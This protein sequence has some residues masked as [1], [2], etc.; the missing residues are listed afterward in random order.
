MSG[1]LN[2]TMLVTSDT[3]RASAMRPLMPYLSRNFFRHAPCMQEEGRAGGK[4][5]GDEDLRWWEPAWRCG[6]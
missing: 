2:E 5:L 6:L 1:R 3:T 4:G